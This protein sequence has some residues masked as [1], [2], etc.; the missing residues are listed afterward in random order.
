MNKAIHTPAKSLTNTNDKDKLKTLF[1]TQL[2]TIFHYL[3]TNIST[4]SMVSEATGIPQKNITRYKRD[5]EQQGL[6]FE[7]EKKLC[8]LT[9]FKAWYISTNKDLLT[10]ITSKDE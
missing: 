6:L 2:K 5:L 9:G 3:Q 1:S 10:S 4:A 8:K 7:V